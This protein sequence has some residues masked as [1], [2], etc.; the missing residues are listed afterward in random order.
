MTSPV[1]VTITGAAG[2]I[3]YALAFRLAHGDVFGSG[4]PIALRLLEIPEL[5]T[6]AE[7]LA[8]ELD[9]CAFPLLK[10][11]EIFDDPVAAFDGTQMVFLV[12]AKP[13]AKGM[14]RSDLLEANAGIFGPQGAALNGHAADDVRVIVVGN[15]ANTNAAIVAAH[16]PD[17]PAHRITAL[18]RLDHNRA[19][20]QVSKRFDVATS[21]ISGLTVWGNHSTT[22]YPDLFNARISGVR[23]PQLV[24][25]VQ[26]LETTFIPRVA[27]RGSEIIETRGASSAASAASATLDHMRDWV[28]G[29]IGDDWTSVALPS[30]GSY[31]VP[32]GL[33]SSFPVRSVDGEWQIVQGLE[34]PDFSRRYIDASV[35]ELI[36]ERDL[37]RS[38]GYLPA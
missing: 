9:D 23:A 7:G 25:D 34:V 16:A 13:R 12:G 18:T 26:W 33:V 19:L 31:G 14:Q 32:K 11:V 2:Q 36:Q 17:V 21:E 24:A 6:A 35:Q 4:V 30:D 10:S 38:L 27:N 15:P 22:Q 5:M 1:S 8:M 29:T 3:G 20:S 28:R 37:V